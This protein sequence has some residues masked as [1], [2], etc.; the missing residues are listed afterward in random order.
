M[1]IATIYDASL[2]PFGDASAV[3]LA[4]STRSSPRSQA[5]L[6]KLVRQMNS[7]DGPPTKEEN[8][9][10]I[11]LKWGPPGQ[12]LHTPRTVD[13]QSLAVSKHFGHVQIEDDGHHEGIEARAKELQDL[14]AQHPYIK[15]AIDDGWAK[16]CIQEDG[17]LGLEFLHG[18]K[19]GLHCFDEAVDKSSKF[20]EAIGH[21]AKASPAV[22][23]PGY[24]R[25]EVEARVRV[26]VGRAL[27]GES[28]PNGRPLEA[29]IGF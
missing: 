28:I 18:A 13:V 4:K 22:Q 20:G 5:E 17:T 14:I 23:G 10:Y 16:V 6:E 29:S 21:V 8:E 15:T 27:G 12:E 11:E 1:E 25:A 7:H 2:D 26:A 9:A 19:V 24:T 3:G